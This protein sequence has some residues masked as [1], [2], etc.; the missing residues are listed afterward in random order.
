MTSQ[1]LNEQILEFLADESVFPNGTNP[2]EAIDKLVKHYTGISNHIDNINYVISSF[3]SDAKKIALPKSYKSRSALSKTL[4]EKFITDIVYKNL[5]K[6]PSVPGADRY[7]EELI[8]RHTSPDKPELSEEDL[9][10]NDHIKD[11]FSHP[12]KNIAELIKLHRDVV[13]Q[14]DTL[15]TDDLLKQDLSDKDLVD[16]AEKITKIAR[17]MLQLQNFSNALEKYHILNEDHSVNTGT[18][19]NEINGEKIDY[20]LTEEDK[21]YLDEYQYLC[22]KY[23][24]YDKKI[25]KMDGKLG[26]I[27][28]PYYAILDPDD[29]Q[30]QALFLDDNAETYCTYIKEAEETAADAEFSAYG[31]V[32]AAAEYFTT[33][34]HYSQNHGGDVDLAKDYFKSKGIPEADLMV[35]YS[36]GTEPKQLKDDTGIRF[37]RGGEADYAKIYDK[38]DANH[39]LLIHADG[40]SH[41]INQLSGAEGTI[42]ASEDSPA[43]IP[44]M[45]EPEKP[46]F[47]KRLFNALFGA[48]QSD[49]DLYDRLTAKY[50]LQQASDRLMASYKKTVDEK[51]LSRMQ[52]L[53]ARLD[54]VTKH[55]EGK[56]APQAEKPSLSDSEL[57]SIKQQTKKQFESFE[58]VFAQVMPEEYAKSKKPFDFNEIISENLKKLQKCNLSDHYC[59]DAI[60]E[61]KTCASLL[62]QGKT[63]VQPFE[64]I[65]YKQIM[66]NQSS[67]VEPS[68]EAETTIKEAVKNASGS[69]AEIAEKMDEVFNALPQSVNLNRRIWDNI[70]TLQRN[71]LTPEEFQEI[72][73]DLQVCS[74]FTNYDNRN[75][76]AS[77]KK[78][79]EAKERMRKLSPVDPAI[80]SAVQKEA[81][82]MGDDLE[83]HRAWALCEVILDSAK[84]A[85]N[86][87][88]LAQSKPAVP[89]LKNSA[90]QHVQKG[91]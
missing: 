68:Q 73:L 65:Q 38:N 58:K 13:K 3:S 17:I 33:G 70:R 29:P 45:K 74:A 82:S 16:N 86:D 55:I 36:D 44:P 40:K 54:A 66:F 91:I 53:V 67:Q 8:M 78:F 35:E 46:G 25:I 27:Q 89:A 28:N 22:E 80:Q 15:G 14:L 49:F 64:F 48:F 26:L 75:G 39:F 84:S 2:E 42:G 77:S 56:D 60:F 19:S 79:E 52:R 59:Q 83:H 51:N 63:N 57:K 62:K 37:F 76:F 18:I 41:L 47:F 61:L 85:L 24:P 34:L 9:Q 11:V 69:P 31:N 1:K 87:L 21:T 32:G 5:S 43:P 23:A 6:V 88:N 30:V 90:K 72:F 4:S 10:Y 12:S 71:N 7:P 50:E 81:L 20:T